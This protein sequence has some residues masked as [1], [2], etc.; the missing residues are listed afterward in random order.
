MS[1]LCNECNQEKSLEDFSPL[2]KGKFGRRSKCKKCMAEIAAKNRKK[3][4]SAHKAAIK[5]YRLS[6]PEVIA[7]R[8]RRYYLKNKDRLLAKNKKWKQNN[9]EQNAELNRRKEHRRRARKL[10]NGIGLY[11]EKQVLELY[12]KLCHICESK[13][14]LSA[15]RRVGTKGWEKGLHID[16]IVPISKGG[17]DTLDN[18]R[19]A[20]ALCN[21]KK[22]D[23]L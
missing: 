21:L 1:K 13:I 5:K 18:V 4:P 14:N 3:N 23:L 17:S 7:R 15:P 22:S 11:T 6:H 12:G 16:H 10:E 20:H 9:P 19:P 8:D 2:I